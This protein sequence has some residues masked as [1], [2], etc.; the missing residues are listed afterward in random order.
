MSNYL[1]QDYVINS[2]KQYPDRIAIKFKEKEVT[3][4]E[5]M[6]NIL[7]IADVLKEEQ[8]EVGSP[9]GV[10][11]EKSD[12]TIASMQAILIR[13]NNYV[14][15]DSTTSPVKRIVSI[16]THSELEFMVSNLRQLE[17]IAK[18]DK[19]DK[20]CLKNVT[21]IC[22]EEGAEKYADLFKKIVTVDY[23]K[24]V[25]LESV[26]RRAV[27]LDTAYILYTSGSTGIPKGVVLS[28]LNC[29][30]F[31]DWCVEYFNPTVEDRFISEAPFHFDLSVFDIYV[32]LAV[33]ATLVI[34]DEI[35]QRNPLQLIKYLQQEKITYLYSVPSLW[36]AFIKYGKIQKDV[37]PD[38]K[39]VLFAGEVFPAKYL[40]EA[41]TLVP[42]AG[43]YN[44]YGLIET[45]VFTYYKVESP[46][47]IG[48]APA[49]IGFACGNSEAIIIRDGQEV[50]EP[51][52]EGELC[53]RG[54]IIMKGYYKN[55]ALTKQS[56]IESPCKRHN[57]ALLYKTGDIAKY[58]DKME[59]IFSGR[60]GTMVKRNGFRIE[61]PEIEDA[62]YTISKV[63]EAAVISVEDAE[64]KLY[65]CVGL[66]PVSGEELSI[67]DIKSQLA[68]KIPTYMIPDY[69][70][71]F[72]SFQRSIN[73]KIDRQYL[74]EYFTKMIQGE[75]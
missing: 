10:Y 5:L 31:V 21:V 39:N 59:I 42:H 20:S 53:A 54:A 67:V 2:A 48:D 52:I 32:P 25:A 24:E 22:I 50:T 36:I 34:V 41:M 68:K 49:P 8:V 19:C 11:L 61:L 74:K 45:N 35:V 23:S 30:T 37:F 1:V 18:D 43:F 70:A 26:E 6:H 16:I 44:L 40:K 29:R 62:I 75:V 57:G 55:E 3:Y 51:G 71:V 27:S 73:G 12:L 66:L 4:R 65:I 56:F 28:H 14:M 69:F 47:D 7:C 72:D 15:L 46:E 63:E 33:G 17:K 9:V 64:G 60:K 13:Q 38:L 58:N